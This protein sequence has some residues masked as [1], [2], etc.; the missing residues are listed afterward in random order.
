MAKSYSLFVED[1]FERADNAS[2]AVGAEGLERIGQAFNYVS[3]RFISGALGDRDELLSLL[4]TPPV[5]SI[6]AAVRTNHYT[7]TPPSHQL[8]SPV[9]ASLYDDQHHQ[10]T[11][12][13]AGSISSSQG[14]AVGR[15]MA[16]PD[17]YKQPQAYNAERM[18]VGQYQSI[19]RPQVYSTGLETAVP[20]HHNH[21]S[22]QR[23]GRRAVGHLNQLR[24]WEYSPYQHSGTTRH[25]PAGRRWSHNGLTWDSAASSSNTSWQW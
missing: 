5:E 2:R 25:D 1:P 10:R 24:R 14:Y 4:C 15:Q 3:Y 20:L 18:T 23:T 19:N 11:G 13:S 7:K 17:Q 22:L 21:T 16:Q 8:Y 9:A 12:G 6:L